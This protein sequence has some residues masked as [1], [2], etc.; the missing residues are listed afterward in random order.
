MLR[1]TL[2]ARAQEVGVIGLAMFHCACADAISFAV[3]RDIGLRNIHSGCTESGEN[4]VY[5]P[6]QT[7]VFVYSE[8]GR[9]DVDKVEDQL[10]IYRTADVRGFVESTTQRLLLAPVWVVNVSTSPVGPNIAACRWLPDSRG[11]VFLRRTGFN[12]SQ[13]M[14]ATLAKRTVQPLTPRGQVV[15]QFDIRDA[16]HFVY[17]VAT[18]HRGGGRPS[19]I[20]VPVDGKSLDSALSLENVAGQVEASA[21]ANLWTAFDGRPFEVTN[22]GTSVVV[23]NSPTVGLAVSPDGSKVATTVPVAEVPAEWEARYPPPSE[24]YAY[25]IHP[26]AQDPQSDDSA[27]S[28]ALINLGSGMTNTLTH[29]PTANDAGWF[30]VSAPQWSADGQRVAVTAAYAGTPEHTGQRPCITVVDI[31][32]NSSA[33]VLSLHSRTETRAGSGDGELIPLAVA[34][35]EGDSRRIKARVLKN[36]VVR[37]I[38]FREDEAGQWRQIDETGADET[39]GLRIWIDED[40]DRPPHLMASVGARARVVWDPNP[41]LA[42]VELGSASLYRW[43]DS[44]AREWTGGLYEPV[45][46]HPGDRYPLVIQ[47]HGFSEHEFST[48]G[49]YT[50]AFA[51]RALA[52][53]GF[54][55]LQADDAHVCAHSA[56]GGHLDEPVCAASGYKAA[57]EQLNLDGKI[58]PDRVGLIGFSRTVMY[59]VE[60]LSKDKATYRAASITDGVMLSYLQYLMGGNAVIRAEAESMIGAAPFGAGL[61]QWTLDSPVFDID[62][63]QAAVQVVALGKASLLSMW[64]PYA[65]L[66]YLHKPVDA[67]LIKSDEH[68]LTNPQARLASQ[69]GTVDWFRFWLKGEEDPAPGKSDQYRRWEKLCDLQADGRAG[70]STYCVRSEHH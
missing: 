34:F 54:F 66:N 65:R 58:D 15:T 36:D 50:T 5:S 3:D 13:L 55:V 29:G 11:I 9:L 12:D 47:T 56:L 35:V 62:Q 42:D 17:R 38:V 52:A 57:I 68:V 25:R 37:S 16:K 10:R 30:S 46:Y 49:L 69:G 27:K 53:Q 8:R 51:A 20:A 26:G 4:V 45:P 39:N 59:V 22:R 19:S 21:T 31:P 70:K 61:T 24:G 63:T 28:Y 60:A 32:S 1:S 14:V 41:Q 64:E 43:R 40:L 2:W 48:S 7:Y 44:D 33:C 67:V 23:S 18:T 6:D